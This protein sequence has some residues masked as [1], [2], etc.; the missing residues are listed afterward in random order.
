MSSEPVSIPSTTMAPAPRFKFDQRYIAPLFISVILLAAHL[1]A[2]VLVRPWYTALAILSAMGVELVAGR[3]ATGKW[4]HLASAY[5]TGISVGILLRSEV[6]WWPYVYC[7]AISILSKYALRIGNKHLWNPSNF[8]IAV[9]LLVVPW[10]NTLSADFGNHSSAMVVIWLVGSFI[11]WRLKR[12]H[13][14]ATYAAS[15]FAFAYIR[16]LATGHAFWAEAAPITGPMYQLFTF[17]MITDP[18]TTVRSRNGQILVAFL[19]AAAEAALRLSDMVH[20]PSLI[21]IHAP[22]YALFTVGP[23]AN[24]VEHYRDKAKKKAAAPPPAPAPV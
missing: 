14:C 16:H 5:V 10:I 20:V 17:F 9:T 18:K 3:V 8:G 2:G 15:F 1:A 21:T 6:A 22:Y 12:F 23:I 24:L 13:I 19:V 4:V 7:S 11:I